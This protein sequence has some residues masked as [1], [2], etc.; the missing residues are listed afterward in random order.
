MAAHQEA[1]SGTFIALFQPGEEITAGARS[2]VDD[3]LTEKVPAPE[4]VLSQHVMTHE[5]GTIGTKAGPIL[6]AGD[7]IEITLHGSGAHGSMR[8]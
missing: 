3:G 6:S 2:M 5:A 8:T 7:S 1:W 4:V